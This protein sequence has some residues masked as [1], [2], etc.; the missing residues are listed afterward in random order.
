MEN[1]ASKFYLDVDD[2]GFFLPGLDDLLRLKNEYPDFKILCFTIPFPKEFFME[3][4]NK[5]FELDKYAEWAKIIN[6]YDWLEVGVHGFNHIHNEF[7]VGYDKV[8]EMLT[9]SENLFKRVGLEYKKIFKAPYWQYSYDALVCLRDRGYTVAIDRNSPIAIPEGLK[10]YTYNWSFEDG[11]IRDEVVKGH[12]HMYYTGGS[13]NS[14]ERCYP[15]LLK[16]I[17]EDAKFGYVS[18]LC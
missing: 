7:N 5:K 18:E 12:G 10:T 3:G 1:K 17:P 6:S 9:A 2:L 14:I 8:D 16:V 4:N 13:K 15:Y 11:M